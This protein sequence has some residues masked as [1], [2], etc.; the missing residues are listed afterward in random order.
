MAEARE[1]KKIAS[2]IHDRIGQ[3]LALARIKLGT[4]TGYNLDP[5]IAEQVVGTSK[6]LEQ[7]IQDTRNLI[8]SVSSPLLYE[9]GLSAA[10]ER[11]VEQFHDEQP[12]NFVYLNGEG[13]AKLDTDVSV[14]LFDSVRELMVN[15]VKHSKGTS[16]RVAM[17]SNDDAV[18]I[19]VTD[20]G[21]GYGENSAGASKKSYGLFSIRERLDHIGG[22]MTIT[23][24][25]TG[26]TTV[27]LAVPKST[28]APY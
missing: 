17:R 20:D 25:S 16:C 24:G 3:S 7:I 4:L 14:L 22:N 21:V 23:S 10:L 5:K 19:S 28:G 12:L 2:E 27:R 1:R 8:F 9:V 11:L 13:E 26:G 6:L 15:A 18:T